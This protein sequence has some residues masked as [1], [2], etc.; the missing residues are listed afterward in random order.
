MASE[1]S[2]TAAKTAADFLKRRASGASGDDLAAI[3]DKVPANP[4]V[5]GDEMAR[6]GN[7]PR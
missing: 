6:P 7:G 5:A 3:L 2:D 4:P 1:K